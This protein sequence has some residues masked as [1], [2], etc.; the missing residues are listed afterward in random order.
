MLTQSSPQ[1][2]SS[3]CEVIGIL[4]CQGSGKTTT[5]HI[6][7]TLIREYLKTPVVSFSIDDFYLPLSDRLVL[8]QKHSFLKYRGPPGTHDIGLLEEI[9]SALTSSGTE[10]VQVPVFDKSLHDGQGDRSSTPKI[11]QKPMRY[12]IFEGWFNGLHAKP[13]ESIP[14]GDVD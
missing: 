11:V 9:L 7:E 8:Q 13:P 10:T 4:G 6:L 2:G 14:P 1:V 12:C 3:K 5:S